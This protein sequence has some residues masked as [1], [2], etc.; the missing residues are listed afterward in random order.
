MTNR[1][2]TP[3]T[4]RQCNHS[5]NS[6]L[7]P[8]NTSGPGLLRAL[9]RRAGW[10]CFTSPFWIS[11][12]VSVLRRILSPLA[13]FSWQD[14]VCN[15]DRCIPTDWLSRG[16]KLTEPHRAVAQALLLILTHPR[17]SS[18]GNKTQ[19]DTLSAQALGHKDENRR[20]QRERRWE[21]KPPAHWIW[22][23]M[24]TKNNESRV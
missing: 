20:L 1:A 18:V 4:Y 9:T 19:A 13:V 2:D 7:I 12:S 5:E 8:Q 10:S 15:P 14:T 24:S 16:F 17:S 6:Y 21:R 3:F 22:G 23:R 11:V